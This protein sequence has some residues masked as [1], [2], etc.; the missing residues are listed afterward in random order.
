MLSFTTTIM[1]HMKL[2]NM[3]LIMIL[4]IVRIVRKRQLQE[5]KKENVTTSIPIL[6]SAITKTTKGTTK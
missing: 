1:L 4:Q 6:F 2:P 3:M 5:A